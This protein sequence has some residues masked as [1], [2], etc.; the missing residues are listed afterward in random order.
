MAKD[1]DK[2]KQVEHRPSRRTL[3]KMIAAT[4]VVAVAAPS[5]ARAQGG[6]MAK[7]AAKYQ[8]TPKNGQKCAGCK[9]FIKPAGGSKNGQCQ[10]VEGSISPNGWCQ[11]YAPAS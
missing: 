7:P 1:K 3:L 11:Y 6:K 10:I 9:F 4:S 2:E 8:D 5:L